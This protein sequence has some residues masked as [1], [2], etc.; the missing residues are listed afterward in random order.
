MAY[1]DHHCAK[2]RAR[3]RDGDLIEYDHRPSLILRPVNAEGTD[4]IPPQNDPEFIDPLHAKCHLER[5]VGRKAGAERTVTTKGSDI[6]LKAKFARL[7]GRTKK[8]PKIKIP[9][10]PF[11]SK[12]KMK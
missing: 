2:C 10:R 12:R 5:T 3:F 8:R 1:E 9:S 6:G 7:E 4:Y 11:P